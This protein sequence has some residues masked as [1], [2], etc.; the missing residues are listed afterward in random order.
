MAEGQSGVPCAGGLSSEYLIDPAQAGD[1]ARC[2]PD[3]LLEV[4]G[5]IAQDVLPLLESAGRKIP[6][7]SVA[8]VGHWDVARAY[9]ET[10][11]NARVATVDAMNL[12]VK[13]VKRFIDDLCATANSAKDADHQASEEVRRTGTSG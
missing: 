9:V 1:V 11:T 7:L 6:D 12:V 4:A 2:R 13:Q 10:A 8:A 5:K 3:A